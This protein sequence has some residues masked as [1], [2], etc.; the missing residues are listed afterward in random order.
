M[1]AIKVLGRVEI[2]LKINTN[3][4]I[5]VIFAEIIKKLTN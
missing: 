3:N 2:R 4:F 5:L 1:Y